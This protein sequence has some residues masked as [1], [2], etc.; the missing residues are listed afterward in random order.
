MSRSI[1]GSK[2]PGH[3]YWGRRSNDYRSPGRFS[4]TQTHR[5]ERRDGRKLTR[6]AL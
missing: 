6:S 1:K 2:G 5:Q 4:K 3:E